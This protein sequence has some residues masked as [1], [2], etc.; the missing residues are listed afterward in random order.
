MGCNG[1][2][3]FW[4]SLCAAFH[5]LKHGKFI[6]FMIGGELAFQV[7]IK[8]PRADMKESKWR[9]YTFNF[10]GEDVLSSMS[11]ST[12]YE[13]DCVIDGI[14]SQKESVR[15]GI[16]GRQLKVL[17]E[18]LLQQLEDAADLMRPESKLKLC[19]NV[20][21]A[22]MALRFPTRIGPMHI[23]RDGLKWGAPHVLADGVEGYV[24]R[25]LEPDERAAVRS[26]LAAAVAAAGGFAKIPLEG[27]EGL[28]VPRGFGLP[29]LRFMLRALMRSLA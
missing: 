29:P 5:R 11:S 18:E 3:W 16:D 21:V 14:S 23:G 17:L 25:S 13:V 26:V 22:G 7:D 6:A 15:R 28:Y 19:W 24:E 9:T 2:Q 4:L 27:I 20:A 1:A 8:V 12:L 10:S